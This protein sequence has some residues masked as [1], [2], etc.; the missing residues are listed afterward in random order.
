MTVIL[1]SASYI[2][3]NATLAS[4]SAPIS[5]TYGSGGAFPVADAEVFGGQLVP[6][7][8]MTNPGVFTQGTSPEG[9]ATKP[10]NDS[11]A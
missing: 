10:N 8:H 6:P 3:P 11:N 1:A 2:V 9:T 7:S 5:F 4:G